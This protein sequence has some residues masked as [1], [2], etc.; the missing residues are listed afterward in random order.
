MQVILLQDIKSL[1]KRGETKNV[2]DGY[3][4]N[5]LLAKGLAMPATKGNINI[6][7]HE[8]QQKMSKEAKLI[9]EAEH[10]AAKLQDYSLTIAAKAGEGGKLFG[11]VTANDI[12]E[13][14]AAAGY[15]VDKR[16]IE[17]PEAMKALG[18]YTAVVK[19]YNNTQAKIVVH[20]VEK[21]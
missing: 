3:A 14:L 10:L 13:A 2:A 6:R 19:L 18:D 12:A 7:D 21:A 16:K 8:L 4:R 9:A 5:Y 15:H 11:S 1:G 20:V 17:I